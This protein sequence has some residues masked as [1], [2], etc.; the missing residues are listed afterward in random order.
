MSLFVCKLF[1]AFYGRSKAKHIAVL[2]ELNPNAF[3]MREYK[4]IELKN[5]LYVRTIHLKTKITWLQNEIA[6]L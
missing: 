2:V 1:K 4:S 3:K 5:N 6:I